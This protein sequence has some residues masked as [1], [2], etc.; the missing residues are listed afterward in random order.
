MTAKKDDVVV[1]HTPAHLEGE[2]FDPRHP[3]ASAF[4][5]AQPAAGVVANDVEEKGQ[6]LAGG[7]KAD[8]AEKTFSDQKE[9]LAE[10]HQESLKA[11]AVAPAAIKVDDDKKTAA[12]A[13]SSDK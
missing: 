6:N 10:Q 12:P 4:A 7:P 13:K 1:Q 5:P 3:A 11:Q 9:V 8:D 2:V